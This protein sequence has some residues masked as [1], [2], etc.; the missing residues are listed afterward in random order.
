MPPTFPRAR[1][2]V[3]ALLFVGWLGFLVYLVAESRHTVV[4]S[5]PQLL[6]SN[7]CVVAEVKEEKGAPLP[8]VL[9][10]RVVWSADPRDEKL[11]D[12]EVVVLNMSHVG[13]PQGYA[14]S[15]EYVLPLT[16]QGPAEAPMYLVTNVPHTPGYVASHVNVELTDEGKDA[17]RVAALVSEFSGLAAD[18][19]RK[20]V[21]TGGRR[22][23][24]RI[25]MPYREAERFYTAMKQAGAAVTLWPN[26]GRVYRATTETLAQLDAFAAALGKR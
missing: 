20:L 7:L 12:A 9:V 22:P 11:L 15:G 25:N 3:A 5:R 19:A 8:R 16:K 2:A 18:E 13:A 24:L 17:D 23:L 26:D 10:K 21:D 14:G 1:L 6:V 4:L